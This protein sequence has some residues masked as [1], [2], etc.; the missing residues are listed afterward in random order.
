MEESS[1]FLLGAGPGPLI[2]VA[3]L[4]QKWNAARVNDVIARAFFLNIIEGSDGME[5]S[6]KKIVLLIQ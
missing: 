6:R 4:D 1:S 2:S 5:I 3:T